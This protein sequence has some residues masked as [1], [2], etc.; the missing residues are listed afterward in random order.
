MCVPP[1]PLRSVITTS[2]C[3][4]TILWSTR[5]PGDLAQ[6]Q[7]P[8]TFQMSIP[9]DGGGIYADTRRTLGHYLEYV[10]LLREVKDTYYADV[11]QY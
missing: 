8:I 11:P 7:I 5:L 1:T 10:H 6:Q 3:G 9:G 4:S 2:A